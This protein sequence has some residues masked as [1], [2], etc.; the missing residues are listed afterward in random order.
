VYFYSIADTEEKA[1]EEARMFWQ[2]AKDY[3]PY[4]WAWDAE[5]GGIPTK[6]F[7]AFADEL[8]RLGAEKVGC[9]VANHLYKLFDYDLVRKDFDFTWI[10]RYGSTKP[11][12]TCDLWQYTSSGKVNGINGNVDLDRITGDGKPLEWFIDEP[13]PGT[14]K[15]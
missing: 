15:G 13:I 5:N 14:D 10:P 7:T 4:F 6:A 2:Y 12:Y 8:R 9:Y 11:V 3:N 1:K